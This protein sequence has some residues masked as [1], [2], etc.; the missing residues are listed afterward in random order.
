[1]L[2]FEWILSVSEFCLGMWLVMLENEG[3]LF[4]KLHKITIIYWFNIMILALDRYFTG[5]RDAAKKICFII[6]VIF[7]LTGLFQPKM[8]WLPNLT[9]FF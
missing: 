8:L 9:L 1:M 7:V 6:F 2:C 5:R 3:C 4:E